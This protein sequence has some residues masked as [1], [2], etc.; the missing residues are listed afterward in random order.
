MKAVTAL[1]QR[2][3]ISGLVALAM[4]LGLMALWAPWQP[5]EGPKTHA[6][7]A[8]ETGAPELPSRSLETPMPPSAESDTVHAAVQVA[9]PGEA[10]GG[11]ANVLSDYLAAATYPPTSRP[12][13]PHSRDLID[14]NRR[15]DIERPV[16]GEP[17]KRYLLTADRY[18]VT[19]D[20][21]V[22]LSLRGSQHGEPIAVQVLTSTATVAGQAPTSVAWSNIG[23]GQLESRLAAANLAAGESAAQMSVRHIVF[24]VFDLHLDTDGRQA[25]VEAHARLT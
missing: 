19:G 9:E 18:W 13:H 20:E 17:G 16:R 10:P 7:S 2:K 14:W 21:S 25:P 22:T 3:G 1:R 8:A 23:E 15:H 24:K 12:L 11:V 5:S 6:D 4:C